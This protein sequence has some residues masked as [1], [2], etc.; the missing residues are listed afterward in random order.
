MEQRS[1]DQ[2]SSIAFRFV[3]RPMGS[4]ACTALGSDEGRALV[5]EPGR[6]AIFQ[7]DTTHQH[8]EYFA[9]MHEEGT[10]RAANSTMSAPA[11]WS[12]FEKLVDLHKFYFEYLIK[13]AAFSFGT[14]GVILT[15]VIS[16]GL[17]DNRVSLAL[18]LPILLSI[19]TCAVY[20]LGF[21]NSLDF[22]K[23]VQ[24]IQTLL[25]L[26]WR[27]HTTML[28]WMSAIF[29]VSFFLLSVGLI[30]IALVPA[31]LPVSP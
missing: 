7:H 5:Y 6:I 11:H 31:M 18:L 30:W 20:C 26:E 2:Q 1:I 19:G 28:S 10:M 23:K 15:Y 24:Y 21:F 8:D 22:T 3:N 25:H 13:A 12:Q 16:A 17:R 4:Q 14:I 27:L 29:A 9:N